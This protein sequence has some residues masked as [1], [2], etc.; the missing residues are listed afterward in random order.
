MNFFGSS[1]KRM[2]SP[3]L[4]N[5]DLKTQSEEVEGLSPKEFVESQNKLK[6]EAIDKIIRNLNYL[7]KKKLQYN[8][9]LFKMVWID[10]IYNEYAYSIRELCKVEYEIERY[11]QSIGWHF[12]YTKSN[13]MD[14][15]GRMHVLKISTEP[16]EEEKDNSE[17][18]NNGTQATQ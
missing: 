6:S 7:M 4:T 18:V 11:Y 9:N 2:E 17:V 8:N 10:G 16:I 15:L 12:S 1:K 3:T 13:P 14:T 5:L